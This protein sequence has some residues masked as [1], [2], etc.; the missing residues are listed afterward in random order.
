MTEQKKG[1]NN[2]SE[3]SNEKE[4]EITVKGIHKNQEDDD[5]IE[6]ITKGI[7]YEK[8]NKIYIS[9][10]DTSLDNVKTVVKINSKKVSVIRFGLT[11]TN[12]IFEKNI[13]HKMPYETPYGVF[14]ICS[15][16]ND[17]SINRSINN[18]EVVVDYYMEIDDMIISD[19]IFYINI[20]QIEHINE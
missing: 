19:N 13:T 5:I 16:T 7:Y 6:T 2:T 15:K 12:L 11:N 20:K 14:E 18:I 8:N 4:V 17:I 9:Y 10:L 1:F 3:I